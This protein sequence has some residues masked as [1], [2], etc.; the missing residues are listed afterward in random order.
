MLGTPAAA[1]VDSLSAGQLHFLKPVTA[2]RLWVWAC[3]A[4]HGCALVAG[5]QT[6]RSVQENA[7]ELRIRAG[8]SYGQGVARDAARRGDGV[9]RP[10]SLHLRIARVPF[11]GRERCGAGG[12]SRHRAARPVAA[13]VLA[14]RP[15]RLNIQCA[16]GCRLPPVQFLAVA[17]VPNR[18]NPGW[19]EV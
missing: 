13:E 4:Q 8:G 14:L 11:G 15:I 19:P 5:R 18:N 9:R 6:H 2:L 10:R 1:E 17:T 12:A 7:P 16:S 3:R